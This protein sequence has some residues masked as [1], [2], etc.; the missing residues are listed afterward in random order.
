MTTA[1]THKTRGNCNYPYNKSKRP[2]HIK[3]NTSITHATGENTAITYKTN[4]YGHYKYN[5]KQH[6]TA[7]IHKTLHMQKAKSDIAQATR[8]DRYTYNRRK[9]PLHI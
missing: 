8:Y 7:I 2:L 9:R 1:I 4:G 3:K 6:E 5:K